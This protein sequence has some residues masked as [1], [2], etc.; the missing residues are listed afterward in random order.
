MSINKVARRPFG[1]QFCKSWSIF[2]KPCKILIYFTYFFFKSINCCMCIMQNSQNFFPPTNLDFF[3]KF[4]VKNKIFLHIQIVPT[5]YEWKKSWAIKLVQR[6][7][8]EQR[9]SHL[10]YKKNPICCLLKK[11][12]KTIGRFRIKD[13]SLTCDEQDIYGFFLKFIYSAKSPPQI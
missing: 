7:I 12:V 8:L 5:L 2:L 4:T 1:L 10:F 6:V 9:D 13:Q 11:G 3:Q